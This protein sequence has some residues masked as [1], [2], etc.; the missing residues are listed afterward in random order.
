MPQSKPISFQGFTHGRKLAEVPAPAPGPAASR[1]T[2]QLP[3]PP[4]P[5][6]PAG[7]P[8]PGPVGGAQVCTL[9]LLQNQ[10]V[11]I[12]GYIV[13]REAENCTQHV[14]HVQKA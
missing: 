6:L 10:N 3:M 2:G 13:T 7:A 9:C 8:E 4:L 11:C 1:R 5:P 12:V 14:L